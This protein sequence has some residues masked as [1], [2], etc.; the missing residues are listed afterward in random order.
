MATEG[1]IGKRIKFKIEVKSGSFFTG[2]KQ[3]E[4]E[5]VVIERLT[6][7]V[8]NLDYW[9]VQED[10]GEIQTVASNEIMSVVTDN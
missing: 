3:E 5:A 4:R 2:E 8:D 6:P 7:D 10:D 9:L 1:L